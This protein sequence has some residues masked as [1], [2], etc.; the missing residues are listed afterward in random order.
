[1][2]IVSE[3][4]IQNTKQSLKTSLL[5][6]NYQISETKKS[7]NIE[8]KSKCSSLVCRISFCKN[9]QSFYKTLI[10]RADIQWEHFSW[11]YYWHLNQKYFINSMFFTPTS[12]NRFSKSFGFKFDVSASL[13]VR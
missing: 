11:E 10:L 12:I 6:F 1:M 13:G 3:Y 9:K 5:I 8:M 4:L 2:D 7:A